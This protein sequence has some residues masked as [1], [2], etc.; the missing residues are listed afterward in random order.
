MP[1]PKS[2]KPGKLVNPAK[3][4]HPQEAGKAQSG[5]VDKTGNALSQKA[6]AFSASNTPAI[7][8]EFGKLVAGKAAPIVGHAL[9]AGAKALQYGQDVLPAMARG[10]GRELDGIFDLTP[11]GVA[12]GA[13][14]SGGIDAVEAACTNWHAV[15]TGKITPID[16]LGRIGD[17]GARGAAE[18]LADTAVGAGVGLVAGAVVGAIVGGAIGALAG[19][20]GAVP[21]AVI[22]A[23][24]GADVG[25]QVGAVA[26]DFLPLAHAVVPAIPDFGWLGD[27]AVDA[28]ENLGG[29]A[30]DAAETAAGD[31]ANAAKSAVAGIANAFGKIL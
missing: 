8:R 23:E 22:G 18:S 1:S 27:K 17:A 13:A 29:K 20:V 3:P 10:G 21:G 5:K 15:K 26:A 2:G 11:K 7:K 31:A 28:A 19:G 14:V 30:I 25:V 6:T 12:I 9:W 24:I 4:H 16:Y